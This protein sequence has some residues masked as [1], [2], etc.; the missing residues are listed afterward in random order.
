M[1][2]AQVRGELADRPAGEGLVELAWAGRGRLDD[3]VLVIRTE[4]AGTAARPPRVQA[5][6]T[7]LVEAVDHIAHGVLVGLQ[8]LGDHRHTVPAGRR[9]QHHRASVAHRTG[10]AP[11]HDPLQLLPLLIGQPAYSDGLCH[12]ASPH[13][14]IRRPIQPCGECPRR[15]LITA[16]MHCLAQ[17][18]STQPEWHS[19]VIRRTRRRRCVPGPDGRGG[20]VPLPDSRRT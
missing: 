10:T 20:V 19:W 17:P 16:L 9:L 5:G 3:E 13:G 15:A 12:H 8:E 4:L 11:A 6:Q 1:H 14:W 7:D 18:I 2:L